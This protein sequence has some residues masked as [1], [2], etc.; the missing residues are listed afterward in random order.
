MADWSEDFVE[1]RG[2]D[3]PQGSK[4][5]GWEATKV[6]MLWDDERLD[7]EHFLA[8]FRAFF[9][10]FGLGMVRKRAF[11]VGF[12]RCKGV[13]VP[14]HCGHDG[15]G[16]GDG[17]RGQVQGPSRRFCTEVAQRT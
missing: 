7:L 10:S 17:D 8:G 15:C 14:L 9:G 6:K 16:C 11:R 12:G 3:A 2:P 5:M 4:P 13:E 1:I